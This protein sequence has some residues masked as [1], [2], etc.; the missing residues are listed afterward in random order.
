M[1]D[2]LGVLL[3]DETFK[4][5]DEEIVDEC[6]LFFGAGS[7]TIKTSNTNLLCYLIMNQEVKE[8]LFKELKEKLFQPYK[9]KNQNAQYNISEI[10]DFEN[11]SYLSYFS[12]CF[13]ESLRIEP[14]I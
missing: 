10:F 12:M 13:N 6:I 5:K 4:G 14:P 11:C 1:N 2:L 8:K 9:D 7:Q 3:E